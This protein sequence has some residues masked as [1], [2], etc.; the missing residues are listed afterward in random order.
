MDVERSWVALLQGRLGSSLNATG[1]TAR[2]WRRLVF[3]F[4]LLFPPPFIQYKR[5][6]GTIPRGRITIERVLYTYGFTLQLLL[7]HPVL[8]IEGLL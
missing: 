1:G 5:Q 6:S 7:T 3:R 4:C 2:T 8:F